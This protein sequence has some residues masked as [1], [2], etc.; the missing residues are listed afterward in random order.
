MEN[1]LNKKVIKKS[2]NPFKSQ[3]KVNTIKGIIDHPILKGKIAY[4]FYE[5]DSFVSVEICEVITS[6]YDISRDEL[7]KR[8]LEGSKKHN[9]GWSKNF[10]Y[11][12]TI[13]DL[14][15]RIDHIEFLNENF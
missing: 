13:R 14:D 11:K 9:L 6:K 10:L 1:V 12:Q 8:C 15:E 4:T 7:V 5:D 2:G 3:F